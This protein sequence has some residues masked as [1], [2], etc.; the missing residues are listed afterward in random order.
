[1]FNFDTKRY[2]KAVNDAIAL[3]DSIEDAADKIS[4]KGYSNIFFYRLW[5]NLCALPAA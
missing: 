3:K 4:K 2:E 1:M 5:R